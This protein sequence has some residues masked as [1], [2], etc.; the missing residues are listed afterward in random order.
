MSTQHDK[1]L[2]YVGNFTIYIQAAVLVESNIIIATLA[3]QG[4]LQPVYIPI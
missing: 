4:T 1:I 2:Y 3:A